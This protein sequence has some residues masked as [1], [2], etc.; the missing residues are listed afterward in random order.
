MNSG[1]IIGTIKNLKNVP[2]NGALVAVDYVGPIQSPF[3]IFPP[4]CHSFVNGDGMFI[5][6]FDWDGYSTN[7]GNI[8]TNLISTY[9]LN[10]IDGDR[11]KARIV[12]DKSREDQ[13]HTFNPMAFVVAIKD[14]SGQMSP[15][16]LFN[17]VLGIT[18]LWAMYRSISL[19]L[20]GIYKPSTEGI[21]LAGFIDITI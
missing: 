13:S 3:N 12:G 20:T 4:Q 7:I 11:L 16:P 10:I 19:P 8:E 21:W 5:L 14:I 17:K 2:L 6:K 1:L 18:K 9:Q 15:P